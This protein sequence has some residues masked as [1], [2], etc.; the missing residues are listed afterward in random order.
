M[1]FFCKK[2]NQFDQKDRNRTDKV[3]WYNWHPNNKVINLWKVD[4]FLSNKIGTLIGRKPYQRKNYNQLDLFLFWTDT[5][6]GKTWA[7]KLFLKTEIKNSRRIFS[8][9]LKIKCTKYPKTSC[10]RVFIVP[11]EGRLCTRKSL[12]TGCVRPKFGENSCLKYHIL[13]ER[14]TRD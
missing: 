13:S 2:G 12:K 3:F 11:V 8:G 7:R 4:W 9:N 10:T 6:P 5:F 14:D 1:F